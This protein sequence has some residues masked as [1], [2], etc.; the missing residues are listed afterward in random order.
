LGSGTGA[1]R[2]GGG[3]AGPAAGLARRLCSIRLGVFDFHRETTPFEHAEANRTR[4]LASASGP[5]ARRPGAGGAAAAGQ[6]SA[7]G[8]EKERDL[9]LGGL[10]T[11]GAVHEVLGRLDRQVTPDGAGR[12]DGRIGRTHERPDHLPSV[13]GP[14]DDHHHHRRSGDERNEILIETLTLVL[15]VVAGGC[16]PVEAAEFGSHETHSFVFEAGDYL[17][18]KAPLNGVGLADDKGAIHERG[19]LAPGAPDS[20]ARLTASAARAAPTTYKDPVTRTRS[21]DAASANAASR[22]SSTESVA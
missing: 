16:I 21:S 12:S 1:N 8:R 19:T 13:V 18:R 11:V 2:P 3:A 5:G 14:F 20:H 9:A 10:G 4:A 22:A 15:G 17:S 7:Q 6:D